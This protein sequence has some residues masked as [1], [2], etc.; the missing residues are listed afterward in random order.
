MRHP[1][2]KGTAHALGPQW[3]S[4]FA[5]ARALT[6]FP[7]DEPRKIALQLLRVGVEYI[8]P[9]FKESFGGRVGILLLL[10][11]RPEV[12]TGLSPPFQSLPPLFLDGFLEPGRNSESGRGRTLGRVYDDV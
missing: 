12:K 1:A 4:V 3:D 5:V 9:V 7:G 10:A 11:F 6:V 2:T 8:D